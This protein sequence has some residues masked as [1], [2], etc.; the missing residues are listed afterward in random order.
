[1]GVEKI[2][3]CVSLTSSPLLAASHTRNSLEQGICHQLA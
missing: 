3:G 1:M 2:I